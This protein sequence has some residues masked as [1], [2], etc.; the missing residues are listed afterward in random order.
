[1]DEMYR[2]MTFLGSSP[3]NGFNLCVGG[4]DS[5]EELAEVWG[6]DGFLAELEI[7]RNSEE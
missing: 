2:Q 7:G 3:V 4:I 5:T 1:M 6:W